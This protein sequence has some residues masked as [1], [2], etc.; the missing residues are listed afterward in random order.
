MQDIQRVEKKTATLLTNLDLLEDKE[1]WASLKSM[2]KIASSRYVKST[3]TT[4]LQTKYYICSSNEYSAMKMNRFVRE[5]W[6]IENKLHW[7]LDVNFGEDDARKRVGNSAK[8]FNLILK[9]AL[10][11]L[12]RNK[13][14]KI[15]I[16]RKKLKASYDLEYRELMMVV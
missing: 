6:A 13:I 7:Q 10:T 8:N 15:S 4:S 2:L 11:L 16:N 14:N 9:T 5:H 12:Q 1:N 3:K